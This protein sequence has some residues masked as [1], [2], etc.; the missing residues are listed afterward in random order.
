LWFIGDPDRPGHEKRRGVQLHRW[1]Q[2]ISKNHRGGVYQGEEAKHADFSASLPPY[3]VRHHLGEALRR[4]EPAVVLA[5]EWHTADAVISIDG[6][7]RDRHARERITLLWNANNL[8][9]FERIAWPRLAYAAAITT[10]SRM[11]R[12]QMRQ[13]GIEAL[14]ISNGLPPEAYIPP[15]RKII[16][17]VRRQLHGRL[18][19]AKVARW[20]ADKNW[21]AAIDAVRLMRD[22][23]LRPLLIARGGAEAHETDV[24][25][26][27]RRHDLRWADRKGRDHGLG[28]LA[29]ALEEGYD[30]DIICLRFPLDSAALRTLYRASDAVLAN[31]R[32]EPFGLVGLETMA[33][34]GVACT[35][36]TGEDYTIP[37]RN[38]LVL[39]T[40]DPHELT[41]V[42]QRLREHPEEERALRRYGQTTAAH[43]AWDEVVRRVLMPR[44]ELLR[45]PA[46]RH[47]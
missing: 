25:A 4:G 34:G 47:R 33:V 40:E 9:G 46:T 3:L 2:W 35:G 31:S 24:R 39:Q 32:F 42:L 21:L 6:L 15:D 7:L 17:A 41:A 27:A 8:F 43:Y 44:L 29:A 13:R 26:A 36:Q 1:C 22:Q 30:V 18:G 14:V 23:G 38:A 12:L 16:A 11:M 10:V 5:E 28:P 19:L 20:D 37:G 45:L